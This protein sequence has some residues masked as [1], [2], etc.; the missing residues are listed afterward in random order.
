MAKQQKV[1]PN[2]KVASKLKSS[3]KTHGG[4]QICQ[5]KTNFLGKL[6][7]LR[8]TTSQIEQHPFPKVQLSP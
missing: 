1:A 7:G 6:L 2:N 3:Y 8:T 5:G 4:I